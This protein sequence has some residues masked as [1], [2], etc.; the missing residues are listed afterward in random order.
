MCV[1]VCVCFQTPLACC[2]QKIPLKHSWCVNSNTI[3]TTTIGALGAPSGEIQAIRE[4][5]Y[6]LNKGFRNEF[7][8][9][10]MWRSANVL[11]YSVLKEARA[12]TSPEEQTDVAGLLNFSWLVIHFW[13]PHPPPD[14]TPS[15]IDIFYVLSYTE[16]IKGTAAG[17]IFVE[18]RADSHLHR[19]FNLFSSFDVFS[20]LRGFSQTTLDWQVTPLSFSLAGWFLV[21]FVQL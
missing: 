7:S 10:C 17:N 1:C 3:S 16:R 11:N 12:K 15:N 8:P 14:L 9:W 19:C 4:N 13:E 5:F 18:A 21:L 20:G 6:P 2:C